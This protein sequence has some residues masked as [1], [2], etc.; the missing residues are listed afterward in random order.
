[1]SNL[2][3]RFIRQNCRQI[4][5]LMIVALWL[6]KP[7]GAPAEIDFSTC[8]YRQSS[9]PIPNVPARIE[10]TAIEGDDGARIQAAID[11]VSDFALDADGF[12]GAVLL[13]PGDFEVADQLIISASG[14]VLRG[15]GIKKSR[16]RA[17]G[18]GRRPLIRVLGKSDR[19]ADHE[20][21]LAIV[22]EI[23]VAGA[24]TL[25]TADTA[26]LKLGDAILITRPST[27]E[28]IKEIGMEPLWHLV[29]TR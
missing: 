15:S 4:V 5:V 16:I 11:H 2:A 1:M 24:T 14:V 25:T 7:T 20:H 8:G 23:A 17:V 6:L 22:D 18:Q 9:V 27:E 10:V 12:R 19:V 28:W 21:S 13:A 3:P 29:E 26:S